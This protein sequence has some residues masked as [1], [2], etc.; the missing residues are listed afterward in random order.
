MKS[1]LKKDLW[2]IILMMGSFI[3]VLLVLPSL[4]DRIPIHW[5]VNGQVDNYGSKESLILLGILPLALY[6]LFLVIP[7]IDPRKDNYEKHEKAYRMTKIGIIL[8]MMAVAWITIL[9]TFGLISDVDKLVIVLVGLLFLVIGNYMRQIRSNFF[10]G[11]KNPWT[12]S[13]EE[14]WKKTH[15]L[16]GIAFIVTGGAMILGSFF[17]GTVAMGL[18]FLG[19][20]FI[21]FVSTLYS[22]L[23]YRKVEKKH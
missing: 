14:V 1:N 22:Y 3:G 21:L 23:I 18:M 11:I 20:A 13:N 5:N 6:L 8:M 16:G 19:I 15:R 7:I 10:F 12:L 4:P 17:S 9:Y 2:L